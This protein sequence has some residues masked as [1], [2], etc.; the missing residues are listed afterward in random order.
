M[1][2]DLMIALGR[3][4]LTSP[5]RMALALMFMGFGLFPVLLTGS[6]SM[7]GKEAMGLFGFVF[8]A[9][10][11]GQE[12][13]SGVLTLAFARP[14]RRSEY[15]LSRWAAATLLAVACGVLQ[16]GLGIVI[17]IARHGDWTLATVALKTLEG[18][19]SIAGLTSVLTLFSALAPGLGDLGLY[20]LSYL[21]IGITNTV[22]NAKQWGWMIRAAEELQRTLGPDFDPAPLFGTGTVS[23]YGLVVYLSTVT[24]CLT[25]AIVALNRKELSYAAG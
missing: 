12:V 19:L 16:S 14:I 22:A 1:N 5:M 2:L 4:R 7:L 20:A 18:A 13:S 17:A 6:V 10:L 8:A 21:A 25:L 3:Q 9:G 23:W 15:V 24:L 11:I